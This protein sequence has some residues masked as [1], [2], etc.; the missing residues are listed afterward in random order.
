MAATTE[1]GGT[2][3]ARRQARRSPTGAAASPA[4]ST[5]EEEGTRAAVAKDPA[6]KA[7]VKRPAAPTWRRMR[8]STWSAA[9]PG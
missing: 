3:A 4:V 1:K 9:A 8:R 5:A 7:A 2:P 6:E